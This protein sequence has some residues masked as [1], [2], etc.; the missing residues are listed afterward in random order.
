[1][2]HGTTASLICPACG[3]AFLSMQHAMEGMTQCPH[4]AHTAPRAQFGT[5]AQVAGVAQVLRRVA[6]APPPQEVPPPAPAPQFQPPAYFPSSVPQP[7]PQQAWQPPPPAPVQI[8]RGT[9]QHSQAL[10][11]LHAPPP[12]AEFTESQPHQ[13]QYSP[14]RNVVFMLVFMGVCGVS[15]WLWWNHANTP[16]AASREATSQA[17]PEVRKAE[18]VAPATPPPARIALQDTQA[19][20]ADAKALVN[21]FFAATT[22]EARAACVHEGAKHSAEIEALFGPEASRKIE[23][24]QLAHL[25]GVVQTLPGGEHVPLFKLI[26]S[27]CA[28]G[29]LLRLEPDADGKRRLSWPLLAETHQ[30]ALGQ[31]L[32]QASADSAWFHVAMRPSHGLDLPAGLRSKYLTFDVQTSA[33]SEPHFVACVERDTPLARFL[34][35]ESD[36]GR[37]YLSRLLVRKLDVEADA[38]CMIIVDCEGAVAR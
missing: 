20:A 15:L 3:Q 36:W 25:P 37:V 11:P 24:R 22:P 2:N 17:V 26:T 8:A 21:T 27:R 31:F 7:Q 13:H 33:A 29:A 38:P 12:H 14:W 16:A 1:M 6:Q 5:H 4:C 18:V 35:R 19:F 23:L 28:H 32:Q 34:D 30:D 9:L 10:M